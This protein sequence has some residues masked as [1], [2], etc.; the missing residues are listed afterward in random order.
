MGPGERVDIQESYRRL[1]D[2]GLTVEDLK[3]RIVWTDTDLWE[4][5]MSS[6]LMKVIRMPTTLDDDT[7][8]ENARDYALYRNIA[9]IDMGFDPSFGN[10]RDEYERRLDRYPSRED[11]ERELMRLGFRV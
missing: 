3:L 10:R 8:S 4:P 9:H 11:A 2:R 7:V 5:G 1:I 6:I